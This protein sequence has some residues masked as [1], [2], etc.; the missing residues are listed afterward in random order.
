MIYIRNEWLTKPVIVVN[1]YLK[2]MIGRVWECRYSFGE[3]VEHRVIFDNYERDNGV[4]LYEF[5]LKTLDCYDELINDGINVY[6]DDGC[7][8]NAFE[9]INELKEKF[10][11]TNPTLR[12]DA[13]ASLF[14]YTL[15]NDGNGFYMSTS[16]SKG[17]SRRIKDV[18][19]LVPNKVVEVTFADGTKEKAVCREPDVFSL[20]TAIAICISKKIMGGSST[21]NNAVKR[22]VKVYE[23]KLKEAEKAKAEEERIAKKRAKR[24]EYKKNKVAKR[25]AQEREEK[26]EI[27]KEA[28]KRAIEEMKNISEIEGK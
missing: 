8:K 12:N 26:I 21:Y 13:Y 24:I 1:G 25:K 23:D 2:G 15:C 22:G 9:I 4:W 28:Y 14:N 6:R 3:E 10:D 17:E 27:Q 7:F 19:I 16:S 20:E 11:M 18:N 5:Q